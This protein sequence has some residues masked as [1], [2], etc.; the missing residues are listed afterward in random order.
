MAHDVRDGL[1]S[2]EF[3]ETVYGVIIDA[4]T[5]EADQVLTEEKRAGLIRYRKN[6][7]QAA[8]AANPRITCKHC[9]GSLADDDGN[10][11]ESAVL[12]ETPMQSLGGPYASGGD[13]LLRS[14]SCPGCGVLLDTETAMQG[15][16]YLHDQIFIR[17]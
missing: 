12:Q 9:G 3:A 11:K 1:T 6:G 16:P 15:D 10:W 17:R 8:T 7:R 13:V 2:A 14:F 4:G 5:G